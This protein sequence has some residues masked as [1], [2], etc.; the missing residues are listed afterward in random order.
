MAGQAAA[1]YRV[2]SGFAKEDVDLMD[3]DSERLIG[4]AAPS[5]SIK[6]GPATSFTVAGRRLGDS[7]SHVSMLTLSMILATKYLV[8]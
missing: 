3:T 1:V 7:E 2:L 5:A 4:H 6:F 8:H